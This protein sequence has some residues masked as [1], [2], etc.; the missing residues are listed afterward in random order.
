MGPIFIFSASLLLSFLRYI[1]S[2][3]PSLLYDSSDKVD[4]NGKHQENI[5]LSKYI[6]VF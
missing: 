3:V 4:P 1:A 2:T 5:E 6:I